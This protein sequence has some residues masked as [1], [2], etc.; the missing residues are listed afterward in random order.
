MDVEEMVAIFLHIIS[1]DVK[2]RIIRR[3][4]AR[5][6]ETISR[7]FNLVLGA[8]LRLHDV[9]LKKPEPILDNSTDE[10]WKWFKNCLGALDGTYIKV[11]VLSSDRPRYRTRKNEIATNV[12][13]V[14]SQDMQFIYVLPGWEGSAADSRVLRDAISRT[15]GLKVPQ[16][17][18]YL[19][20]AGYPNGEGFLTP[21]RG[22]RYH[23]NDWD[24][25][26]NTPQEFFNMKHSSARNI[27]ERAFGLLKGRWTILR[28]RSYYPVKIQCRIILAC[29]LLHNLIIR[30]MPLDPLEHS[31][32]E[33]SNIGDDSDDIGDDCYRHIE[34]SSAE[35]DEKMDASSQSISIGGKKHQWTTVE[36]SKLVECLMDLTNGGRWKADNG[37]F[38][39]GYLQQLEKMMAEKIHGCGLKAQPHIDSRVRIL[40]KQYHA[41]S[42]MLG[43]NA[44][45]FG[46]NEVDKCVVAEKSVFDEWVK[47]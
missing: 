16:G 44:S 36:D 20:D 31:P 5:S 18:Y 23:L 47:A 30:E 17:Y 14:V 38:K 32:I 45:G 6:G 10:R 34:T 46:W 43:P 41:I 25:P 12:L 27:V 40:K 8:L 21:Y 2:N 37:T 11:N 9:L 7:Q 26:P 24:I 13:G 4:F 19:C 22:Q 28:G 33:E 29:C 3:Q 39:P 35:L 15:N 1:H 42:K